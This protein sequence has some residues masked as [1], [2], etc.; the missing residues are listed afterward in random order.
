MNQAY[1]PA[2]NKKAV[3][4]LST[5]KMQIAIEGPTLGLNA[6]QIAVEQ[7][8]CQQIIDSI[9]DIDAKYNAYKSAVLNLKTVKKTTLKSLK[10]NI[11]YHKAAPPFN[12][13]IGAALQINGIKPVFNPAQ[14]RPQISVKVV[15]GNVQLKFKKKGVHGVNIYHRLHGNPT[16]QFLVRDTK[17]PYIHTIV[18]KTPGQAEHWEYKAFGIIDDEEIGLAS[19]IVEVLYTK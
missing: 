6:T 12:K 15:G 5:Y 14:Y 1:Y 19:N 13:S 8:Q 18:L 10:K 3:L 2:S 7:D 16:W 4:W 17:S 11:A 9:L